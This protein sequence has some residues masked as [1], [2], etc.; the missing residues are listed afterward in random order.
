M[1]NFRNT[2]RPR[3]GNQ[4]NLKKM[5]RNCK[6]NFFDVF[7][8]IFL[9]RSYVDSVLLSQISTTRFVS[10]FWRTIKT[11]SRITTQNTLAKSCMQSKSAR[12]LVFKANDGNQNRRQISPKQ[13]KR[14]GTTIAFLDRKNPSLVR[15]NIA[16][17]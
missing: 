10:F 12:N 2:S 14:T 7:R 11:I 15:N 4:Q 6:N 8:I 5:V 1:I 17:K 16:A 9:N 3:V 13:P